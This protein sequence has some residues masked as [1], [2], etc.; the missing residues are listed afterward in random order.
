MGFPFKSPP[1]GIQKRG[2]S[3]AYANPAYGLYWAMGAGKTF[4]TINLAAARHLKRKIKHCIIIVNPSAIKDVWDVEL[5]KWCPVD[6]DLFIFNSGDQNRLNK[7]NAFRK[8]D[9]MHFLVF[10]IEAFSQGKAIDA[11]SKYIDEFASEGIMMVI[12]E[13]TGIKNPT[14]TRSKKITKQGHRCQYRLILTGTPVTQGIQD[15]YSQMRF[16]DPAIIGC[17]SW[18]LFRNMYCI[19]GGFEG[20]SIIGYQ[21]EQELMERIAPFV[22]VVTKEEAMPHLLPKQYLPPIKVKPSP[23]QHQA[24]EQLKNEFAAEDGGD[25]LTVS[26]AMERIT[27]YQQICG[28]FFPYDD[29]ETGGYKVKAISGPNPKLMALTKEAQIFVEQGEKC[30]IWARFVP[31][32]ELIVSTL[33]GLFG[34]KAVVDFYGKT[35]NRKESTRRFQEDPECMFIVSTQAV[36]AKGQ[37]WTAGTQ[38]RYYSQTFSYE[39]RMQSED[40]AHRRGQEKSVGYRDYMVNVNAEKMVLKAIATKDGYATAFTEGV[41]GMDL[42][43]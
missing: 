4:A 27:R 14:A 28:G 39:D 19:M 6:Y 3:K 26:M 13:A 18:V 11:M 5:A 37:T 35:E 1:S 7:H 40:R 32:I 12:D 16:L 34:D 30:I 31:E 29:V 38:V 43:S 36:G 15:L 22:D 8:E 21:R 25:T 9:D 17:K 33:R 20:R 24:M 42:G 2:L 10:G 41:Q 23:E